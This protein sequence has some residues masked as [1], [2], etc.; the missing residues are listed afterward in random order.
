MGEAC[1]TYGG[2]RGAYWVLVGRPEKQ[3]QLGKP[4]RRCEENN[5]MDDQA[6]GWGGLD[7]INLDEDRNR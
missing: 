2:R 1:S 7:W 5:K 4:R 3:R 6:V